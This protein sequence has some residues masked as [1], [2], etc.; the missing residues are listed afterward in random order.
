MT[1]FDFYIPDFILM[2]FPLPVCCSPQQR[3]TSEFSK[4]L[5]PFPLSVAI[6]CYFHID[7][8][9]SNS[10]QFSYSAYLFIFHFFKKILL[11]WVSWGKSRAWGT[12]DFALSLERDPG[13]TTLRWWPELKPRAG[14]SID[15]APE[16]TL[17]TSLLI[18]FACLLAT[19][20]YCDFDPGLG[21]FQYSCCQ[22]GLYCALNNSQR[23]VQGPSHTLQQTILPEASGFCYC[24]QALHTWNIKLWYLPFTTGTRSYIFLS[25]H[26][27]CSLPH[28][29]SLMTTSQSISSLGLS[30]TC[31]WW[32]SNCRSKSNTIDTVYHCL[33][34]I[35]Q[36]SQIA[37][38]RF[39]KQ[40]L[41]EVKQT[42]Q[43][44]KVSKWHD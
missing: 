41:R 32:S 26:Y 40:S 42:T 4:S 18:A 30:I 7:M 38:Y 33:A 1:A 31:H 17:H 6:S 8:Q 28:Q 13:F 44:N 9:S 25:L 15:R 3:G 5:L 11:I 39:C 24:P 43:C 10:M 16:G 36:A 27:S 29:L 2:I 20:T 23:L 22:H 14:H 37:L 21:C 12:E 35:C 34:I 19:Y